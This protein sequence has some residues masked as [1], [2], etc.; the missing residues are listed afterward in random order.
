MKPG[1]GIGGG[2]GAAVGER[3]A[4]LASSSFSFSKRLISCSPVSSSDA[5]QSVLEGWRAGEEEEEQMVVVRHDI[6][7]AL[8]H[9]F[10]QSALLKKLW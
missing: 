4:F 3:E 8:Q 9:A 5:L 7:L 2:I 1:G 6:C 10:L